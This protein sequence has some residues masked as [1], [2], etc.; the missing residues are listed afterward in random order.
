MGMEYFSARASEL[1]AFLDSRLA[2][3]GEEFA[4]LKPWGSDVPRRL[5]AFA[6]GGK[7]IRG[8]LVFLGQ[9]AAGGRPRMPASR[10]YPF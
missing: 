10:S 4:F 3:D 8:G 1:R 5:S 7:L 9:E 6:R 2:A